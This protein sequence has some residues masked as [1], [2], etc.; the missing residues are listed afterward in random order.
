M[1]LSFKFIL[2]LFIIRV[3][4]NIIK[5]ACTQQRLERPKTSCVVFTVTKSPVQRNNNNPSRNSGMQ[6]GYYS[7]SSRPNTLSMGCWSVGFIFLF[8]RLCVTVAE[9]V[10]KRIPFSSTSYR[11]EYFTRHRADGLFI[12][13]LLLLSSSR[14]RCFFFSFYHFFFFFS[15]R[16]TT[17]R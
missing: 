17:S 14:C 9:H 7:F 3:S 4:K 16:D 2:E 12:V 13:V 11:Y 5:N 15:H 6:F 8:S 10:S 1:L